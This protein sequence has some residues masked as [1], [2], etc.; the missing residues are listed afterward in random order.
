MSYP[1]QVKIELDKNTVERLF[2][3]IK[4]RNMEEYVNNKLRDELVQFIPS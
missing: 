2:R 1:V 4:V 3:K